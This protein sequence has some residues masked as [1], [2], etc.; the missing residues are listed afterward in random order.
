M[1]T[2]DVFDMFT[3]DY[4]RERFESMSLRDWLLA[5]RDDKMLY[6]SPA[7]RMVSAIG[8]PERVDTA[9]DPRLG[10]LFFNRTIKLYRAF[11]G[12]YGMEDTVE[13]IVGYFKHAAQGLEEKRQILYLL[14]PVGG[15]KSSL[16][17]RLKELMEKHPIYV[18]K[19]GNEVSPVFESPLGL[20]RSAEL[21]D[22]L[23]ERYGIDK[24][25]LGN[26]MS[27]W[28]VKRLDEFGGDISKFEVA[29]LYPSKLRQIAVAKTEPGDENNQDISSLVGKVD[30]R[31][32]EHYSQNDP[33][34]YAFSGGLC[35]ANQGLLEF[36][37]MFKA[38]IK[39]LHPLLT[40]TQEGN[41][42]GTETLGPIPFNGTILAHSNEAEWTVFKANKNNEAFLDRI[43]VVTVPYCLRVSEE[44]SIYK[45]LIGTSNLGAASCAPETLEMLAKFC[46]AT[47]LKGGHA[48][49][50]LP[51]LAEATVN[52][53]ILP[54]VQP[55]AI[56]AELKQVV[57]SGVEVTP[58]ADAG[59]PTPVSPLRP[60]VVGAYTKA[61]HARFPGAQIIPQMSTGATDGLEFRARGIPVY[62]VDGGWGVSPD[63]ERAHGKDERIPVQS[64]WDSTMHWESM[65]RDLAGGK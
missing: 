65:I 25:R 20:F 53:R 11:D 63:D 6:A 57:G 16:A 3:R 36:V 23:S 51:Q 48:D 1:T 47:R 9:H 59:R 18:L 5:A 14:G 28:A 60:D 17:E 46:V 34:A 45:K 43:C 31:K 44:T 39:V 10:R 37:E 58:D 40:A 22:L 13:R 7:E 56:E 26:V 15:G 61:V 2:L 42:I 38:P 52:C 41:Y 4:A 32:L 19:A 12:F 33:D 62:G 64:L 8:E 30:I 21:T 27:P 29:R 55:A 54:G 49:N 50:A 35:R 24:H